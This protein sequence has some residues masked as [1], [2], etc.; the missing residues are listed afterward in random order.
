MREPWVSHANNLAAQI[1][2]GRYLLFL[3]PDTEVL[4]GTF[5][6]LAATLDR[7]RTSA[8]SVYAR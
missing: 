5:G 4:E 3:N 1:S 2:T 8:S 6:D 7:A